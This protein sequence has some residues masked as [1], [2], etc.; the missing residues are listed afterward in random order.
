MNIS[1]LLKNAQSLTD[2][3]FEQK[4]NK[5]IRDNYRYKNLGPDNKAVVFDLLKKYRSNLKRGIGISYSERQNE[6]YHLYRNRLKLNLTEE[7]LKDI[8]EILGMF[9]S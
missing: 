2:Y 9:K 1:D 3:E 4:L 7:D 6:S 5:L 8:K